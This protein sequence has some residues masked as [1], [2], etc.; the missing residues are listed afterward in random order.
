MKSKIISI[1]AIS[2]AI[3]AICLILGSYIQFVDLISLVLSSFFVI[4]PLYYNSYKGAFLS[5]IV[6][7]VISLVATIPTMSFSIVLPAYFSFFGFYPIVKQLFIKY[8]M[9]KILAFVIGLVWCLI[10][11]YAIYYLYIFVF[12]LPLDDLPQ[13]ILDYILIFVGLAGLIF[14]VVFDR[15]LFTS[16]FFIDRYLGKIIK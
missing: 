2:S 8:N 10:A 7:G 15:F 5:C 9:N 13:I 16:K 6:A 3:V 11:F 14:F 1:S 4:L 12:L